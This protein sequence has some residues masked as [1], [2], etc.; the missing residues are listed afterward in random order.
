MNQSEARLHAGRSVH[1]RPSLSPRPSFRFSE[2]LVPRLL[3][4][5]RSS[6]QGRFSP[7]KILDP[8]H[9]RFY[10]QRVCDYPLRE[11]KLGHIW[12]PYLLETPPLL[13][14][15]IFSVSIKCIDCS[16]YNTCMVAYTMML[17]AIGISTKE[18]RKQ[19]QGGL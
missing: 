5:E 1:F 13:V 8:G 14:L 19:K 3:E 9:K 18:H 10:R 7:I 15:L 12:K 16:D 2:G 11:Q 17:H 4:T 6:D